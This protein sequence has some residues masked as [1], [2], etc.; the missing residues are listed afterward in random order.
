VAQSAHSDRGTRTVALLF[1]AGSVLFA[2]GSLPPFF[3]NV[4]PALVAWTFVVGSVLFTTA[5]AM[6]L[7]ESRG[8]RAAVVSASAV[9]LVGT[10]L[11]NLSTFAATRDLTTQQAE[12]LVWAPDVYGSAA[13]LVAGALGWVVVCGRPWC[14]RPGCPDWQ[15]AALNMLG[16]LAFGLAAAGALLLPTTGEPVNIRWVNAGTFLGA[17]C[18]FRAALLLLRSVARSRRATA[19]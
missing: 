12:R 15:M 14:W 19:A 1:A 16:A 11:F 13:F 17:C 4:S 7:L 5:A 6:Q 18:F 9:Q 3:E 8:D 10:V 2:L